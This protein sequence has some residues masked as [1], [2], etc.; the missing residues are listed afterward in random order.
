MCV[1]VSCAQAHTHRH[2]D[3]HRQTGTDTG[4][5]THTHTHTDTH[6]DTDT[7]TG[8]HT[9]R[10]TNMYTLPQQ[11]FS[12]QLESATKEPMN[13]LQRSITVKVQQWPEPTSFLDRVQLTYHW[14]HEQ[15]T[16]NEEADT[17][18]LEQIRC[19]LRYDGGGEDDDDDFSDEEDEE[20]EE[21]G[22]GTRLRTFDDADSDDDDDDHRYILHE[23]GYLIDDAAK[24]DVS[25][26]R[27]QPAEQG[28]NVVVVVVVVCVCVCVCLAGW[29]DYLL[30]CLGCAVAFRQSTVFL[31]TFC[32]A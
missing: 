32:S 6:T 16:E 7:G 30:P 14:V 9:M 2:T 20:G 17:P 29:V 24:T 21:G 19:A 5:D 27:E 10:R 22:G 31:S 23:D 25:T 1:C 8:T 18:Y 3:T 28:P 15:L 12:V 26:A 13:W 11:E 4:T